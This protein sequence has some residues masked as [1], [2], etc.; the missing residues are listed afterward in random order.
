[1][2]HNICQKQLV[3]GLSLEKITKN[4]TE[5][6]FNSLM[7]ACLV[8]MGMVEIDSLK[9]G[10]QLKEK[11]AGDVGRFL[12]RILGLKVENQNLIFSYFTECMKQMINNAQKEGRYNEGLLDITGSS[13][14]MVGKPRR[15]FKDLSKSH[16]TIRLVEVKI[17]RGMSWEAA[18]TRY[19]NHSGSKDGFYVSRREVWGRHLYLLATQKENSTHL[20]HI[21]RPNTGLSLFEEEKSDL[22][23]RYLP[24]NKEKA[25]KCWRE[26]YEQTEDQCVH[27]PSCKHGDTCRVGSRCYR[28]TLLCGSI[29]TLVPIL[30]SAINRFSL[31]LNLSKS[32]SMLRVVRVQLD[33]GERIV[34]IRYPSILIPEVEK[35]LKDQQ[36][37]ESY[38]PSQGASDQ[39][40]AS[41][42]MATQ[43]IDPSQPM[44]TQIIDPSQPIATQLPSRPHAQS[45]ILLPTSTSESQVPLKRRVLEEVG[46]VN[47]RC[48]RHAVT[49]PVTLKNF[50]K[51]LIKKETTSLKE[52]NTTNQI[53]IKTGTEADLSNMKK[54]SSKKSGNE[55]EI[56]YEAF[57]QTLSEG[58]RK[59]RL[60][61]NSDCAKVVQ[62][63]K[64]ED[65]LSSTKLS[66]NET[67]N[68]LS[69]K[70]S[71]ESL[72][73]VQRNKKPKQST[74]FTSFAR[75][76]SK[77]LEEKKC[78]VCQK[79]FE[80]D[81]TNQTINE[82]IDNCLIE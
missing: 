76:N 80:K 33:N 30:E 48:L 15:L 19:E 59:S 20:F 50:F 53:C 46:P 47:P 39:F 67:A 60:S 45:E 57:C 38:K 29:M 34:G 40:S 44:A 32:E 42:P 11:D 4:K 1:M 66:Q 75:Q 5:E 81:E 78:P 26:Q 23:N 36:A 79:I 49:P 13:V 22:F 16:G 64:T 35:V 56:N 61:P 51:P 58:K 71:A 28:L 21:A 17:D 18:T 69:K 74:L 82:H 63:C 43:I 54:N 27:G 6:E 62:L 72:N 70:R 31:K 25:E 9:S 3:P 68:R 65:S 24:A 52:M 73:S 10:P 7:Q 55:N 8:L 14:N 2:Y 12:N 37:M 41:Q 77:K